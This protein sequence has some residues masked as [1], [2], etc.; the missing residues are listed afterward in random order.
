MLDAVWEL[1]TPWS[2]IVLIGSL[3][4]LAGVVF[5]IQFMGLRRRS[6]RAGEIAAIKTAAWMILFGGSFTL[7]FWIVS[8]FM[9]PGFA[10][11]LVGG[12]IWWLLSQTVLS[13]IW[14]GLDRGLGNR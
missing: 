9:A 12:G 6:G 8:L 4:V 10:R 11:Y 7:I 5:W 3:L 14:T 2:W 1:E 13:L